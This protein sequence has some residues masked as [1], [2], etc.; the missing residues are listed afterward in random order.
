M[1][2][3]TESL[4]QYH[5][6]VTCHFKTSSELISTDSQSSVPVDLNNVHA[7]FSPVS[8]EGL[9][10]QDCFSS[11]TLPTQSTLSEKN[12]TVTMQSLFPS[13]TD[14]WPFQDHLPSRPLMTW[15]MSVLLDLNS[16]HA[17]SLTPVSPPSGLPF[18][19][20][21]WV[22]LHWLK[23]LCT[24]QDLKIDCVVSPNVTTEHLPFWDHLQSITIP[25][26]RALCSKTPE[27]WQWGVSFAVSPRNGHFK[28]MFEV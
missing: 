18:Q 15:K 28:T 7:I 6:Q 27:Q 8:V 1:F 14:E 20:I 12:S 26:Q 17:E 2:H 11:I 4:P 3:F 23:Q 16:N 22:Q 9:P 19:D 25:T 21:S 5:Q 24:S 10:L 13:V